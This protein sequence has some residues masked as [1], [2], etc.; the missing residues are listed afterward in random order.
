MWTA[1]WIK[2]PVLT[3][4]VDVHSA[5]ISLSIV[6]CVCL[7]WITVVWAV[8][9]AVTHI[10]TVIIIL[11]GVE[12]EWTV[13]LFQKGKE[14]ETLV[15]CCFS[16][17]GSICRDGV[18][19]NERLL[20]FLG[21]VPHLMLGLANTQC[22][23]FRALP[24]CWNLMEFEVLARAGEKHL[25]SCRA[26][27]PLPLPPSPP[28]LLLDSMNDECKKIPHTQSLVHCWGHIWR[29][30]THPIVRNAIIVIIIVTS[31][32]NAV[33]I[34]ILLPRVGEVGAVVLKNRKTD[35]VV[36]HSEFITNKHVTLTLQKHVHSQ[37]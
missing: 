11:P 24:R 2:F 6:V 20:L 37:V 32:S 33:L 1:R 15:I 7:V 19:Q 9:T 34:V 25:L 21:P 29:G 27:T 4:S 10:I 17:S 23:S 28:A 30:F 13:V 22:S 16:V 8:I 18:L 31:I 26:S 5:G 14:R 36:R 12:D 3:V 35:N